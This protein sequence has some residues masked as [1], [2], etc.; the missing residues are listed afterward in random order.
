MLVVGSIAPADAQVTT[1][2]IVGTVKDTSG[3]VL[4]GVNVTAIN[5]DTNLSRSEVSNER[6]EYSL[7][8]LPPG[9][10]R[11]EAELTGFKRFVQTG[12]AIELARAARVDPVLE[13]G[14]TTENVQ[15]RADAPLVDT[16]RVALG[17]TVNQTEI[18]NLPLVDRDVYALLDLTA[19]IDSSETS[20]AFGIPGQETLVNGSAN[21]GAGS[22]NYSLDGG[23]NMSGLRQT[24]NI[25]PNPD[26]VREFRVQTNSYSAEHGR[27]GGAVV[28]V[29]TKSGTNAFSGSLFEFFRDDSMNAERWT[30]G[31]ANLRRELFERNN[32]GGS[33]GGPIFR[34]RTFFFASYNGIRQTTAAY[35]ASAD[36]PSPL[37]RQGD[38]SQTF[39]DGDLVVLTDPQTRRPFPGNSIPSN[40]FDPVAVRILNDWIPL[41]NLPGNGYE[42]EVPIPLERNEFSLKLDHNLTTNHR[43][44]GSYF[45]ARGSDHD[46]LGGDLAWTD[47]I[48]TWDQHNANVSDLWTI[49][50]SMVNE[51][52]FTFVHNVGGRVN[53]PEVS[54]A[55]YGSSFVMQGAP[56]LPLIDVSGYFQLDTPIAGTRAG[57]NTYQIRNVL[58]MDKGKHALH[59]GGTFFRESL[60]H[61]TTLDNYGEFQFDGDFTG[62]GFA[63]FLLGLPTRIDQDAPIDKYDDSTYVSAFFQDD[64]RVLPRLTLNLGLRYDLQFPLKDPQNRKLTFVPGYQSTVVPEAYPGMLFP[65]DEGPD[66]TIPDTIAPP[67]YNNFAPRL[68]FAWDVA[69]DGRTAVRGAVGVFY[70]TIGGNQWNATADNQPFAIRQD[71]RT[72]TLSNPYL[73]FDEPP[74]PY[75]YDPNNIRFILPASIGGISLDY[76]IPYMYQFNAAVQRQITS[77]LSATIAYVGARGRNL[78]FNQNLNYPNSGT[79]SVDSRRP[80][81][82]RTLGNIEILDT[83]LTNQYRRAAGDRGQAPQPQF[84]GQRRLHVRQEPRGCAPAGR[85]G[86]AGAELPRHLGGPWPYR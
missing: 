11:L 52:H 82:P 40:R 6:G 28:D 8:F 51:L 61:F 60:A 14:G 19:G 7:Q 3:G 43:L 72:G 42:V 29:I 47:R 25:V 34:N 53:T 45:F 73:G 75:V 84:P 10:Y 80:F 55:D 35:E 57:G 18:L 38:Y 20:N 5:I 12:V 15:V 9:S 13:V 78:P 65:G 85:H 77:D 63:D 30:I 62:D 2:S 31:A 1:G 70:G 83:F 71:W 4:P 21:T 79:G 22:V 66:G 54:I 76:D 86:T 33:F 64:Y 58:S 69:G 23:A 16:A 17:R 26:A 49:G 81:L 32:F 46:P 44:S 48:F 56:A 39:D 36:V 74:F 68:G 50:R 24:G 67:D 59:F 27:F 37:E 41:P